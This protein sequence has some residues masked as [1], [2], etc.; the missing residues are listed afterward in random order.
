MAAVAESDDRYHLALGGG[1]VAR[2]ALGGVGGGV[3]VG[4]EADQLLVVRAPAVLVRELQRGG[5][6]GGRHASCPAGR[7]S[8]SC[9]DNGG[10][11]DGVRHR[12]RKATAM[13]G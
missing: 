9:Y 11:A 10:G 5:W 7:Y 2:R 8:V 13:G 12:Q 4:V 3:G 1:G 6:G